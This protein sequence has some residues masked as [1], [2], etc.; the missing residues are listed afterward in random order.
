MTMILVLVEAPTAGLQDLSGHST[1]GSATSD[2]FLRISNKRLQ[3]R[4]PGF[5]RVQKQE[6]AA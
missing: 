1:E 2:G 3:S 6:S 4:F 5:P